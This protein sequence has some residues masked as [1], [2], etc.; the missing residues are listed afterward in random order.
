M[1]CSPYNKMT[2]L[3]A[4]SPVIRR[5]I[6]LKSD[7][8]DNK[9]L[10]RRDGDNLLIPRSHVWHRQRKDFGCVDS[11]SDCKVKEFHKDPSP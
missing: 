2:L 11:D 7:Q 8:P 3:A 9:L 5:K 10:W 1:G 4:A 6:Y